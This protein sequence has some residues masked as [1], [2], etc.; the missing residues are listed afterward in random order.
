MNCAE[1]HLNENNLANYAGES[2]Y[3]CR[4]GYLSPVF[5]RDLTLQVMKTAAEEDW[6]IVVYD[7]SDKTKIARDLNLAAREG[8]WFGRSDYG[9]EIESIPY[10]AFL[11]VLEDKTLPFAEE[12]ELPPGYRPGEMVL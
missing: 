10:E 1:L 12:E 8:G 9:R 11:P 4:M 6:S 5:S 7:C 3:F 2:L